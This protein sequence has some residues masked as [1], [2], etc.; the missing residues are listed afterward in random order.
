[1]SD[2]VDTSN[3]MES[4]EVAM[5]KRANDAQGQQ[6][7]SL[8]S[9]AIQS[10]SAAQQVGAAAALNPVIGVNAPVSEGSVGTN[11]NLHV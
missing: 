6:T 2:I 5:L 8:L 7:L 3:T 9:G 1:M 11:I 4:M 10:A